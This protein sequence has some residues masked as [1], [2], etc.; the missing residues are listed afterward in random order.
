MPLPEQTFSSFEELRE[1]L[2]N[3]IIPNGARDISGGENNNVLNAIITFMEQ[4]PANAGRVDIHSSGG[5]FALAKPF[6]LFNIV[7]PTQLSIGNN[8]QNEWYIVNATSGD[9]PLA[10]NSHYFYMQQEKSS[11]PAGATLHL[12]KGENNLWLQVNGNAASDNAGTSGY[13]GKSGFSG[14]SGY[15]GNSG[16][17]GYSGAGTSGFSG[18][19]GAGFSGYSG[20][21]GTG[22]SGYSGVSGFS[23]YSG[24]SGYSG[25]SGSG[26]SGY[27]GYSGATG[28][29]TSGFSGYSGNSTSGYSGFSGLSGYSGAVGATGPGAGTSGFSGYSGQ[30]AASGYS[31]FSGLAAASGYSGYS[32]SGVSGYSGFSGAGTSG[33]SGYS[34]AST[35]GASGYSGFSGK[36]GYS[37]YSGS[38]LSG[39]SGFSGRSGY[40]GYS[41][42]SGYSGAAGSGS[43]DVLL[44]TL[45][46]LRLETAPLTTVRYYMTDSGKEGH[47]WYDSS[48]TTTADNTGLVLVSTNGKRFK[49]IY[50][51]VN[52]DVKWF[53]LLGNG[54][55]ETTKFQNA[56]DNTNGKTLLIENITIRVGGS[57]GG[58]A[59]SIA[60]GGDN[61]KIIGRNGIIKY[62]ASGSQPDIFWYFGAIDNFEISGLE[63]DM[64][65]LAGNETSGTTVWYFDGCSNF[66]ILSNYIHNNGHAAMKIVGGNHCYINDNRVS[67]T[68]SAI[69]CLADGTGGIQNLIVTHNQIDHGTSEGIG[70]FSHGDPEDVSTHWIVAYNTVKNKENSAGYNLSRSRYGVVDGNIAAN[71]YAFAF[72]SDAGSAFDFDEYSTDVKFV[73]NY[74]IDCSVG[75]NNVSDRCS[76]IGMTFVNLEKTALLTNG[77]L[78]SGGTPNV[79]T[80]TGVH[81]EGCQFYNCSYLDQAFPIIELQ[82]LRSSSVKNNTCSESINSSVKF[83][84]FQNLDKCNIDGNDAWDSKLELVSTDTASY[85]NR[86]YFRNNTFLDVTMAVTYPI[87]GSV[88]NWIFEGNRYINFELDPT[89]FFYDLSVTSGALDVNSR[90]VK[91]FYYVAASQTITSIS[92][93]WLGRE[94][95]FQAKGAATFT[96]G[97]NI[98]MV[99]AANLVLSANQ[100][101]TMRY[102]GTKWREKYRSLS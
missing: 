22:G 21:S 14:L 3:T 64:E 90:F 93:S 83:I 97:S 50:D 41:G 66:D 82:S 6:T 18:Y 78:T 99:G 34:G 15:S 53:D 27:S 4:A 1:Y 95:T 24:R 12:A 44:K 89:L 102:D 7:A 9:I 37:G 58:A 94:I 25:Y 63:F 79:V 26:I 47:W 29:G 86:N 52:V 28:A 11:I 43:G 92:A 74:C 31:G 33:F 13:S 30:T 5:T 46:A 8:S 77:F 17:S 60:V 35:S 69:F 67:Y 81:I 101:V 55:N 71:C 65:S 87:S 98:S 85:G 40:S 23:G 16:R 62:I 56:I 57:F 36:S 19:S 73:G 48:D 49:R 2:N 76:V 100:S 10:A 61:R 20:Y 42:N 38:G 88:Y 32:G 96:H 84:R 59:A 39:Y 54:T 70:V 51:N 72:L 45:A 68:D 91:D 75:I 80:V